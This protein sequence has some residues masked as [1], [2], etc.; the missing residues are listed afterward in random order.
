MRA[1][2][3]LIL[4]L[5]VLTTSSYVVPAHV[6]EELEPCRGMY[7]YTFE[8]MMN[9]TVVT[10]I[11]FEAQSLDKSKLYS[12]W[13]YLPRFKPKWR[14]NMV[15]GSL[16]NFT[17]EVT[18]Y[19]FYVV[20]RLVLTPSEKGLIR[21]LMKYK[22]KYGLLMV[23]PYA[24]FMS[25]LIGHS[26]ECRGEA[27]VI[28]P[29]NLTIV[30]SSPEFFV[31]QKGQGRQKLKYRWGL[32]SPQPR[33]ITLL[34]RT[35]WKGDVIKLKAEPFVFTVPA[36]Y[37]G[38]A[39]RIISIYKRALPIL[40]D[41]MHTSLRIIKIEFFVPK[42]FHEM[43]IVGFVPFNPANESMGTI[44]LNIFYI[45][46]V[47]GVLETGAVHELVH[48]M[49]WKAGISPYDL[50]WIHEGLAEYLS[51]KIVTMIDENGTFR[52]GVEWRRRLLE[53]LIKERNF[54][55]LS[56][57]QNWK[58]G[59]PIDDILMYYAASF[60]IFNT[61]GELY[62]GLEL[63]SRFFEYL[64][65]RRVQLASTTAFMMYLSDVVGREVIELFDRWGFSI[66]DIREIMYNLELCEEFLK[67]SYP[68]SPL[69]EVCNK[70]IE[71]TRSAL[72]RDRYEEAL[73]L[74]RVACYV[75][76]VDV[77]V[78]YVLAVVVLLV[79]WMCYTRGRKRGK[80]IVL[81]ESNI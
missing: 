53:S 13:L 14:I 12:T 65:S 71:G 41:V 45:R 54:T 17:K 69:R 77:V 80:L 42:Y 56:F 24:F 51:L 35:E 23:E 8:A 30:D 55:D 29:S 70:L 63:Y 31:M 19:Y 59:Q 4:A 62:G 49:L 7:R 10:T 68:L 78:R 20:C 26:V 39:L 3:P 6:E 60:Y 32:I 15:E 37:K 44:H 66:V 72:E 75:A 57:V 9:G 67:Y 46:A 73:N 50:L 52:E 33:R 21:F 38:E 22:F 76:I 61:L 2:I 48:H 58:P 1:F 25:P 34:L 36:R 47:N 81:K 40:E 16:V 11:Y 5:L 27:E 28:I 79:T 43:G 74:S 18:E 64:R